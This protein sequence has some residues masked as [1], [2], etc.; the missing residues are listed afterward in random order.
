MPLETFAGKAISSTYQKVVQ[1]EGGLL[2]DG[3]GSA[4]N[5]LFLP[6]NLSVSGT[7]YANNTVTITQSYYSGSNIFGDAQTDTQT[8]TGSMLITGSTIWNI[9][10]SPTGYISPSTDGIAIGNSNSGTH[11]RVR[12]SNRTALDQSVG[13]G[14]PNFGWSTSDRITILT[15]GTTSGQTGIWIGSSANSNIFKVQGDS[16]VAINVDTASSSLHVRGTGTTNSTTT[17]LIENANA[18]ASFTVK[19]DGYIRPYYGINFGSDSPT[20]GNGGVI[21]PYGSGL[22][23]QAYG[24]SAG[25]NRYGRIEVGNVTPTSNFLG[26]F[27]GTTIGTNSTV[28][29]A[30]SDGSNVSTWFYFGNNLNNIVSSAIVNIDSTTRGLLVPRTNLTSNISSP[31]QGLIIY[32]TG[33]TN[34]GLYYYSS[35]S[36]KSWTK[37]LN[38]TGSQSIN[39]ALTVTG[40]GTFTGTVITNSEA[41][42]RTN[43]TTNSIY[44]RLGIFNFSGWETGTQTAFFNGWNQESYINSPLN[45]GIASTTMPARLRVRGSGTTN[46]TTTLLIENA[47]AS[48]SLSVLDNG[49][50]GIGTTTPSASLQIGNGTTGASTLYVG[51]GIT[52]NHIIGFNVNNTIYHRILSNANTGEFRLEPGAAGGGHYLTVRVDGVEQIRVR[53]TGVG[54]GTTSPSSKLHVVGNTILSGSAGTGSAL[55]AYKSGSTVVDIQGSQGQLFSVIDSLTG[56]LMSVNDVSGLPILEVFSDDK[57]VMGTYGAPGLTVSGSSMYVPTASTAPTGG[58]EGEFKLVASGSSFYVYGFIGGQWRSGSLF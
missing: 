57:V 48:S 43:G 20:I 54:I 8:F 28:F 2:A 45:I 49:N 36:I 55:L 15:G 9:S 32:L 41:S 31:A 35:G 40:S 18:S 53:S 58:R 22:A 46:S 50:V 29:G 23:L 51:G 17:L 38:D 14:S 34:E 37:V 3:T 39:G 30:T 21:S 13:F 44:S 25:N 4:I 16:R 26:Y 12:N 6:G 5:N 7:I 10:G 56:S 1:I 33:S 27:V 47:N 11:I 42:F 19:D 52:E 24:A